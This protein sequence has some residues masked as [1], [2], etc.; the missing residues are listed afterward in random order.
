MGTQGC[1]SI[2]AAAVAAAL[3][4]L[5][6]PQLSPNEVYCSVL[7]RVA[8]SSCCSRAVAAARAAVEP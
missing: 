1:C 4:R 2:V 8:I 3:L 6:T 7:Q 5:P